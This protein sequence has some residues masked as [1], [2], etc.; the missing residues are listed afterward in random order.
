MKTK[1]K[2]I[3]KFGISIIVVALIFIAAG[4]NILLAVNVSENTTEDTEHYE[5][6]EG[7]EFVWMRD[8][9]HYGYE[10]FSGLTIREIFNIR[11]SDPTGSNGTW[12]DCA[13]VC[14]L[15]NDNKTDKY[16][17]QAPFLI[18]DVNPEGDDPT[19]ARMYIYNRAE[20]DPSKQITAYDLT[21]DGYGTYYAMLAYVA[22]QAEM[23]HQY[24]ANGNVTNETIGVAANSTWS[25][26]FRTVWMN[27][28]Y[29]L[30]RTANNSVTFPIAEDDYFSTGY[31]GY[32]AAQNYVKNLST[33]DTTYSARIIVFQGGS[34]ETRAVLTGIQNII[35]VPSV[36]KWISSVRVPSRYEYGVSYDGT[37]ISNILDYQNEVDVIYRNQDGSTY[38]RETMTEIQK[39]NNSMSL[40]PYTYV[41]YTITASI[42]IAGTYTITDQFDYY[43]CEYIPEESS[44]WSLSQSDLTGHQNTLSITQYFEANTTYT[45]TVTLYVTSRDNTTTPIEN[46]ASLGTASSSD[47][48]SLSGSPSTSYSDAAGTYKKYIIKVNGEDVGDRSSYTNDTAKANP[49][50]V[51]QGD[52]VTYR[53]EVQ[54]N[55]DTF[56]DVI[57]AHLTDTMEDGLELVNGGT[58]FTY[59]FDK[60]S[61]GQSG[62]YDFDVVVTKSN[63][64]LLPIENRVVLDGGTFYR[65]ISETWNYE[66]ENIVGLQDVEFSYVSFQLQN[67]NI[68]S[69]MSD[70]NSDYVQLDDVEIAGYVW[71]DTNGDGIKDSG[72]AGIEGVRVYLHSSRDNF[73]LEQEARGVS[74]D[75]SSGLYYI[76]T[77]SNGYYSFGKAKKGNTDFEGGTRKYRDNSG[78]AD[79]YLTYEYSGIYYESTIYTNL[80]DVTDSSPI[81]NWENKSHADEDLISSTNRQDFN[82]KFTTISYNKAYDSEDSSGNVSDLYYDKDG[83]TSTLIDS[84]STNILARSPDLFKYNSN[85]KTFSSITKDDSYLRYMNLG[86]IT[87]E[88]ANLELTKDVVSAVIEINGF[89]TTYTYESLG[90]GEYTGDY[91]LQ[92]PYKLLIYAEDYNYRT[93]SYNEVISEIK[94]EDND[95]KVTLTY[96]ITIRNS[97]LE[98]MHYAVIREVIDS[99]SN[100]MTINRVYDEAGNDYQYSTNSEFNNTSDY[101]YNEY[102]TLFIT[103][104]TLE[105]KVLAQ[106]QSLDIYLEYSVNKSNDEIII[107]TEL[108]LGK[109]NIAQIGAFSIYLESNGSY[110]PAGVVDSNSNPGNLRS[111]EYE[112]TDESIYEDD[113][114]YTSIQVLL[115]DNTEETSTETN[116]SLPYS[117]RQI[118]GNVWEDLRTEETS[119]GKEFGDGIRNS[120]ENGA[121]NIIVK[122]MEVVING[123]DEY[124]V[125]TGIWTTTDSNG[126]YTLESSDRLHAGTYVVRFIYGDNSEYLT[127]TDGNTIRYSGQDYKSTSYT[128]IGNGDELEVVEASRF[129]EISDEY[130]E[131]STAKDNELRRLEVISYSTTMTYYLDSILKSNSVTADDGSVVDIGNMETLAQNTGMYADTKKF[132]IQIEYCDYYTDFENF[133]FNGLIFQ[134]YRVNEVNFGLIERPITKLQLMNDMVEMIATTSDGSELVHLY[135]DIVY[136]KDEEN[137]LH[138]SVLDE[139]R[140][141]GNGNVQILNR[142]SN[143]QGFRYVNIDTELLQG[144]LVTVKYQIAIA[145]ISDIDT[146]NQNLIG[147]VK[148]YDVENVT[149]HMKE[150]TLF[151][152]NTIYR[153]GDVDDSG[154]S[155]NMLSSY[156]YIELSKAIEELNRSDYQE[157]ATD[158][159]YRIGYFLGESYYSSDYTKG[160]LVDDSNEEIVE[161]RVDQIVNYVDNDLVF[162]HEDNTNDN[163][164]SRF[165]TYTVSEIFERNLLAGVD[166]TSD[167]TDGNE[168]YISDERNNLVFNIE[169]EEINPEIYKFLTPITDEITEEETLVDV[170]EEG[171]EV[172]KT[173]N[174]IHDEDLY[175]IDVAGSRSLSSEQDA[176]GLSIDNLAE[177]IKITNTVGRKVYISTTSTNATGYIG[178][179]TLSIGDVED[180]E[181]EVS[182]VTVAGESDTD[183]AEYTTFSPPTG[184]TKAELRA[185]TTVDIVIIIIVILIVAIIVLI[186][187]KKFN[188]TKKIYK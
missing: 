110:T 116:D 130:G 81:N 124:L 142:S 106:N 187:L 183:Y 72:E 145:N 172:N 102:N 33:T 4:I 30:Q 140:S 121:Q 143:S 40:T 9:A 139:S 63:M 181:K 185:Q 105:N 54:N 73:L 94:G 165:L 71:N 26:A 1:V 53:I 151:A 122:L 64:Y 10:R 49:I 133:I 118:R 109:V 34:N 127:T 103:G 156:S 14:C 177:I 90:Q 57:S 43:L 141:V 42:N 132:N 171:N 97:S 96:R 107:D 167:I 11:S 52:I 180:P 115:R 186:V 80:D 21:G 28:V 99:Y 55:S 62:I 60:I 38:T 2:N 159:E 51:K 146:S 178:N 44:N 6:E 104:S 3:L 175:V 76:D 23:T 163:G 83:H 46:R 68:N 166:S 78:Y 70:T 12:N 125:D 120:N 119:S 56:V 15:H 184:Y 7:T 22:A 8:L 29:H 69:F 112:I 61:P 50:T 136:Y 39:T 155:D 168:S 158:S 25:N 162:R 77:D 24:D 161:T 188:F 58:S 27:I 89:E 117:Y 36:N 65:K 66:T 160:E 170:D 84:E 154:I 135:F 148:N 20:K 85:N 87:R 147:M 113:T 59:S 35:E 95:L 111:P 179:T 164:V 88:Q 16:V 92:N 91:K 150:Q 114:F 32:I 41:T 169:S 131:V 134:N 17:N 137:I 138:E 100:E 67:L 182:I 75:N 82:E 98:A 47:F 144:M 45:F 74:Y 37:I 93:S 31:A 128:D 176:E 101:N 108:D 157:Y 79:Y 86:L 149:E 153:Y 173:V 18:I 48:F 129:S 5:D 13:S 19:A 174:A 152:E 123:D 126:N